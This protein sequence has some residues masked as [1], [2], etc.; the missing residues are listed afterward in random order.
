MPLKPIPAHPRLDH[1]RHQAR[2]LQKAQ[3]AADPEANQRIRE[4][5]PRLFRASEARISEAKFTLTDAQ[6]TVAREYG[7]PSWPKLKAA[8][9]RNDFVDPNVPMHERIEDPAFRR[10]VDLIDAGDE[11]GLREWLANHPGLARRRVFFQG[12]GY[13]A[14]PTLL[15]F[16]AEN[17]IRHA[18]LPPSIVNIARIL[19]EAGADPNDGTLGLVANGRV[20]RE[21]RVQIPLVDFLTRTNRSKV[22]S[23]TVNLRRSRP[24]FA[25]EPALI[26]RSRRRWTVSKTRSGFCPKQTPKPATSPSPS[27]PNTA[28]RPSSASSSMR[29]RTPA[30]TI[31]SAPTPTPPRSTKRSATA[32][33]TRSASWSN[34]VQSGI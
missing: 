14:H 4:F 9:E 17:P 25:T 6:L 15:G 29:A 24:S 33:S 23:P 19:V 1:F 13:F 16:V 5:H 34:E 28:A 3:R 31:P 2:D 18:T 21:C 12:G 30:A 8:A 22:P 10:A 7:F 27:P 20:P 26:S 11:A 32:I